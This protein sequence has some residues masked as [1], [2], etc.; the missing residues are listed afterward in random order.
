M[1]FAHTI[2]QAHT[3]A[4]TYIC[5][6]TQCFALIICLPLPF[7]L[8][9]CYLLLVLIVTS[10]DFMCSVV[11]WNPVSAMF[12]HEKCILFGVWVSRHW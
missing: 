1:A 5:T 12:V 3:C 8:A 2:R 4:R 7:P 9:P 11:L 6:C 10:S